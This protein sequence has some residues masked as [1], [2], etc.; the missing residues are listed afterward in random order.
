MVNVESRI[1]TPARHP[2]ARL[3]R[4]LA[5]GSFPP[6]D[7]GWVR[8]APWTQ[9]IQG[10]IA[11]TDHTILAISYDVTDAALADLGATHAEGAASPRLSAHLAGPT[12]WVGSVDVL[13]VGL[14]TGSE[15]RAGGSLVSRSDQGQHPVV[16]AARRVCQDVQVLGTAQNNDVVVLGRGLAGIREIHFALDESNRARGLG[17]QLVRDALACVPKDELV[18]ACVPAGTAAAIRAASRAGMSPIG[19]VQLFSTRPEHR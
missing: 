14:G 13:F 2:L 12:G 6:R 1:W 5:A 10:V 17:A 9:H 18:V 16:L 11:F 4:E 19:S 8:V 3:L 15:G 7:H